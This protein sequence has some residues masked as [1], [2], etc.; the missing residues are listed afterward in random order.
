MNR[1]SRL[2]KSKPVGAIIIAACVFI[3]L[4][5]VASLLAATFSGFTTGLN[6]AVGAQTR[7][8]STQIVYNYESYIA[9][10]ITTSNI[11]QTDI[12]M[13]DIK[14]SSGGELFGDYLAEIIHLKSDILSI[15]VYD[16]ETSRCLASSAP[17]EAGTVLD[18]A[19]AV[20]YSEALNDPTVHVFSVPYSD[21]GS[22]EYK[23]NVSKRIQLKH[24]GEIG[25]LKIEISFQSFID[26]VVK[27]NLGEGGHITIID[28]DYGIVYTSLGDSQAAAAETDVIRGLV[29]GAR[30]AVLGRNQMAVN[31]D[32]LSG[33]KWRICVFINI[34]E[35]MAIQRR[36]LL[37]TAL[38]S[39]AVLAAGVML[40]T[41]VARA[42]T[43]PMR[44]LELALALGVLLG[45]NVF[46]ELAYLAHHAVKAL[47]EGFYLP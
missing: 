36:F 3:V 43:T 9:S 33:T 45:D 21:Y 10:I 32:T 6:E 42:I 40:F 23:V 11:I 18:S 26:L 39:C 38:V 13:Y 12:A 28:S 41:A 2:F 19:G 46:H 30:N 16:Y 47:G 5:M 22:E 20:W 17:D 29:L 44:Q 8:L 1:L 14:T 35:P 27:S 15:S 24:S 34:D 31:V 25:V 37:S 4:V 7:E